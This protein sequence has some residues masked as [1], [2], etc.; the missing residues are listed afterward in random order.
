MDKLTEGSGIDD[1]LRDLA[2]RR[3][4]GLGTTPALSAA[5]QTVLNAALAEQFPVDTA[6]DEVATKRD[7]LLELNPPGIPAP[8]ESALLRRLVASAP[9]RVVTHGWR[10]SNWRP[11]ASVLLRF[12]RWRVRTLLTASVLIA[13]AILCFESW[14]TPSRQSAQN[15][16]DASSTDPLNM[17]ESVRL[18]RSPLGRAELFARRVAIAQ[19]SLSTTEPAS[20][21]ATFLA[22]SGRY[23]ADGN[24]SSLG[25]RLDLPATLTLMEDGLTRIP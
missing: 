17:D 16:P 5:R 12:Y 20:L 3:D 15:L 18:D 25:L 14:E 23:F 13:A 10:A 24:Q 6:L 8:V 21:Q 2:K 11:G 22:D 19:F 4:R 7:Q 9:G 1:A